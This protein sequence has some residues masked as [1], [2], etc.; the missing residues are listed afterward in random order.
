MCS[1]MLLVVVIVSV[2]LHF[3]KVAF[4]ECTFQYFVNLSFC[5]VD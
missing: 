5:T 1:G 4:P 2:T 3:A